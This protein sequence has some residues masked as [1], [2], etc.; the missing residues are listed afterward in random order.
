M[1]SLAKYLME[2]GLIGYGVR[3]LRRR[4]VHTKHEYMK[5]IGVGGLK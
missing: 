3:M 2:V 5:A 1:N 4:M